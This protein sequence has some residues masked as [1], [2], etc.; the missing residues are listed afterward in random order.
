VSQSDQNVVGDKA[1]NFTPSPY[2]SDHNVVSDKA[3]TLH[4]PP[5]PLLVRSYH[6]AVGEKAETLNFEPP[7]S[8]P[9]LV[10]KF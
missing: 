4:P 2:Y 6:N 7:P 10:G 8:H 1:V 3:E 5:P 9:I